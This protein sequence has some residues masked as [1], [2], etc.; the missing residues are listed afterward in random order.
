LSTDELREAIA[1]A[2]RML[3][4]KPAVGAL[5]RQPLQWRDH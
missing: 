3:E 1:I 5:N 2:D 4:G